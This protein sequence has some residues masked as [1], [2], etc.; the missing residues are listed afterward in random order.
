MAH[1]NTVVGIF[2][3]VEAANA[4]RDGLLAAGIEEARMVMSAP[5]TDDGI[6]GEYPGQSFENQPGQSRQ[7]SENARYGEAI[8]SGLCTL[9][10][11]TEST[12]QHDEVAAILCKSG[13]SNTV[14][15]PE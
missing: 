14:R 10:V 4:A 11:D 2:R 6:G 15:P 8:R 12:A 5:I 1:T 13:A 7:D 9:S 3:S